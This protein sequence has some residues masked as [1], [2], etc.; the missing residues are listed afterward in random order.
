MREWSTRAMVV[1]KFPK[2]NKKILLAMQAI[3][4][5]RAGKLEYIYSDV[6]P[7]S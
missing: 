2:Q 1:D 6:K 7:M 5:D 3:F 4:I